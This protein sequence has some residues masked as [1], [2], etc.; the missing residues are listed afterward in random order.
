MAIKYLKKANKTSSTDD[1]KTRE[2]VGFD[3]FEGYKNFTDIDKESDVFTYSQNL[4]L[5]EFLF[6]S[7]C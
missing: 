5:F 2:I 1:H 4:H 7:R 6:L 3:T